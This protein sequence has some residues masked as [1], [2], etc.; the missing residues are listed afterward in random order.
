MNMSQQQQQQQQLL[1][2]KLKVPCKPLVTN[3]VHTCF[4]GTSTREC[5]P[6]EGRLA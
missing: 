5:R 4:R 6:K 2:A 3:N 1:F